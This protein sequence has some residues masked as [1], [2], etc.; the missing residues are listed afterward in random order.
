MGTASPASSSRAP[1]ASD[2]PVSVAWMSANASTA[3]ESIVR[4]ASSR[5]PSAPPKRSP[6]PPTTSPGSNR[7]SPPASTASAV[8]VTPSGTV[9]L[10]GVIQLASSSSVTVMPSSISGKGS[11]SESDSPNRSTPPALALCAPRVSASSIVTEAPGASA[12][13]PSSVASRSGTVFGSR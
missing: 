7:T 1:P 9:P 8:T 13:L 2:A 12:R 5:G 6:T 10:G 11:V 4:P 3:R